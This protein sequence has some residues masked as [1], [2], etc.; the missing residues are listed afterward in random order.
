MGKPN[1]TRL[2]T[3]MNQIGATLASKIAALLL[4]VHGPNHFLD[5]KRTL[6]FVVVSYHGQTIRHKSNIHRD[7][8]DPHHQTTDYHKIATAAP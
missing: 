5:K 6:L 2:S 7:T 1:Y 8:T 4:Y 3:D